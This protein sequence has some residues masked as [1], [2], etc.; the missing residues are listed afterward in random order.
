[1]SLD[2]GAKR[3]G[4]RGLREIMSATTAKQQCFKSIAVL[5]HKIASKKRIEEF[6]DQRQREV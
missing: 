1:M 6:S 4:I 3:V 5:K 2:D